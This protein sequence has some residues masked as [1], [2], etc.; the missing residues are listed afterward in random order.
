MIRDVQP[1]NSDPLIRRA[2]PSLP[3]IYASYSKRI[4]ASKG[5]RILLCIP[6]SGTHNDKPPLSL[7]Y[8]A[9]TILQENPGA[10]IEILDLNHVEDNFDIRRHLETEKPDI[11]GISFCTPT[12]ND[13][14][15]LASSVKQVSEEIIVVAGGHHPS[16]LPVATLLNSCFDVAIKGE[17]ELSFYN[18]VQ[19]VVAGGR[20]EDLKKIAGIAFKF[21]SSI[22]INHDLAVVDNLNQLAFPDRELLSIP[23]YYS[24]MNHYYSNWMKK[25]SPA[26]TLISSRGCPFGCIYCSSSVSGKK[27]RQR[28]PENIIAEIE[29]L[30]KTY[31]IRHIVFLDDTFTLNPKRIKALAKL[32]IERGL[33]Q[34]TTWG[35]WTRPDKVSKGLLELMHSAGC[36]A[37]SF[38]V[39]S[40]SQ[41]V[42]D[43]MGKGLQVQQNLQAIKWAKEVGM[44]D[45][46]VFVMVGLPGEAEAEVD[47][48]INFLQVAQPTTTALAILVPYPGT[49]I[50]FA[51]ASF[52]VRIIE[53]DYRQYFPRKSGS[54]T[55]PP[56]TIETEHANAEQIAAMYLKILANIKT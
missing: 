24:S 23:D 25:N 53:P 31:G 46:R 5:I 11:V 54:G 47:Q 19:A 15:A 17:G 1:P 35:C 43:R 10:K 52:G 38:G 12:Y 37:V 44:I 56:I 14:E 50:S 48:T 26:T 41:R 18:L 49:P 13:A 30:V 55:L 39:E 6:K 22:A 51:P 28:S 36:R 8:L 40:G 34:Q 21:D 27:Y 29:Q 32:L 3:N 42:L 2:R 20:P 9:A 16:T 45:V 4:G 7:G 33:H